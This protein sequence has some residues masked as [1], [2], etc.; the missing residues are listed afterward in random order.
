MYQFLFLIL[1][2]VFAFVFIYF[3]M[4]S[5]LI[6]AFSKFIFDNVLFAVPLILIVLVF[7]LIRYLPNR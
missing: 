1:V 4:G 3:V 2:L 7:A 5:S 6:I